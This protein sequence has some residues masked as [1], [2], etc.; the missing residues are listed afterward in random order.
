MEGENERAALPLPTI[1]R[2]PVYLRAVRAKLARGEASVSSAVLA[3]ELGLDAVLVR[4]DLAMSGVA[5]RP[6]TGWP[7]AALEAA[8]AAAIGWDDV[9]QAALVGAG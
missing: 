6:R 4:K 2:Y 9:S 7:T 5:G 8:L 1:R 3:S